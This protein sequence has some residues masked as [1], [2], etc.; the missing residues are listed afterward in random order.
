MITKPNKSKTKIK[1]LRLFLK[2][3]KMLKRLM[4][5]SL[6]IMPFLSACDFRPKHKV[7][8]YQEEV[9]LS[10]G[11]FIWVDIKRHYRLAGEPFQK[12]NYLPSIV[13]ISWDTGFEGAGRKSVFFY[14]RVYFIDK[15]D[16]A[17]Y[18]IGKSY[19]YEGSLDKIRSVNC[20]DYGVLMN[21]DYHCIFRI[22]GQGNH[23]KSRITF[24]QLTA[25]HINI[26]N[27][28]L[29]RDD[30][31]PM[32]EFLDKTKLSWTNKLELQTTQPKDN[33]LIGRTYSYLK[34]N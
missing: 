27:T 26:L 6:M 30:G 7:I 1:T 19:P 21:K 12:A 20:R 28:T 22:N 31:N 34:V 29:L 18:V 11:S 14:D 8:E 10:D 25:H 17:W 32:K 23:I 3:K 24:E 2:D 15:I 33:Q 13:E 16:G 4:I 5:V 9:K